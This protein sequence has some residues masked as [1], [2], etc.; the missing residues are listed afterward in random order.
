MQR[1][2][3]D[4]ERWADEREKGVLTMVG[5]DFNARTGIEGGRIGKVLDRRKGEDEGRRPKNRKINKE[6]KMLVGFLEEK[7]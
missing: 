5:E 7:R 6:R 1:I 2:P 3:D 4:L